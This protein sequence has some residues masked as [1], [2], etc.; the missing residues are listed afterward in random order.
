MKRSSVLLLAAFVTP[1]WIT[2]PLEAQDAATPAAAEESVY[3]NDFESLEAGL[4]PSDFMALQGDFAIVKEEGNTAMQLAAEPIVEGAV[5]LGPVIDQ[6]GIVMARIKAT[7]K[8]RSYP[9]FGV[10]LHGLNGF[11]LRVVPAKKEIELARNDDIVQSVEMRWNSGEWYF[12]ELRVQQ[13][14]SNWTVQGRVWPES[15][16]RPDLPQIDYIAY[17]SKLR[18]KA[19]VTGTA[20]SGTPIFFDDVK[21]TQLPGEESEGEEASAVEKP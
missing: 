14:S 12:V 9:R 20:Y 2:G 17:E 16:A 13:N 1:W 3:E 8:G 19:S 21:I 4:T 18:G 6:S 11:R 10:G 15:E 5:Q 7:R